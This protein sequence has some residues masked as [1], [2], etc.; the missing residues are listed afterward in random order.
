MHDD[1]EMAGGVNSEV[2]IPPIELLGGGGM[3]EGQYV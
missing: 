1:E 3:T 2:F